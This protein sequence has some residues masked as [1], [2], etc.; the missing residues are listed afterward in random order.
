MSPL[1]FVDFRYVFMYAV[2]FLIGLKDRHFSCQTTT[3]SFHSFASNINNFHRR[4][5]LTPASGFQSLQ[6][7]LL[8]NKMGVRP[9]RRIKVHTAQCQSLAFFSYRLQG[10]TT[11]FAYFCTK[12]EKFVNFS[13]TLST[14]RTCFSTRTMCGLWKT[15]KTTPLS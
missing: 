14:T 12:E 6:F 10:C 11:L 13:T 9:D 8:E 7:R 5:Y 2:I 4:K 15:A 1:D 3:V